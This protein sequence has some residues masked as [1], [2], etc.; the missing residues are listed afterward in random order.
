MSAPRL[1]PH[2]QDDPDEWRPWYDNAPR[3]RLSSSSRLSALRR[4]FYE[5]GIAAQ[6]EQGRRVKVATYVLAG[7]GT[8]VDAMHQALGVYAGRMGWRVSTQSFTDDPRGCPPEARPAFRAACRYA[9]SGFADGV[10]ALDRFALPS[11]DEAYESW[12]RWLHDR[13]SFIAFAPLA[14]A[15]PQTSQ[16]LAPAG[17]GGRDDQEPSTGSSA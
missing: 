11:S 7:I 16:L 10:L 1:V 15:G 14:I 6:A 8:D 5:E 2:L 3:L 9:A 12:L 17:S 4:S 13:M